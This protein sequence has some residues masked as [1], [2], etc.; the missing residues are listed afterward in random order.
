MFTNP[1]PKPGDMFSVRIRLAGLSGQ[2]AHYDLSLGSEDNVRIGKLRYNDS[3]LKASGNADENDLNLPG[4]AT[5]W[6][7]D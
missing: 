2:D 5:A 4:T 3:R 1:R 7:P 6:S